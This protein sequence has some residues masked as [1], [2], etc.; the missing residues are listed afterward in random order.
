MVT[1][2]STT[3]SLLSGI[4][5]VL[6]LYLVAVP[7]YM[8]VEGLKLLDAVYFVTVSIT[9]AGYGDITPQTDA[10][11]AFAVVLL[12]AGVS[13]FFYHITHLG[14]FRERAIDPHVQRRIEMLR[15]LTSLQTGDVKKEEVQ[16]IKAKIQKIRNAHEGKGASSGGS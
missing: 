5:M 15:N 9:S 6:I 3:K 8:Y 16:K 10:G 13:I 7:F 11:K 12:I 2:D 14:Q 1:L 4:M